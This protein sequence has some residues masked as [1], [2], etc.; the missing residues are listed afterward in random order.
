MNRY[1]QARLVDAVAGR[2]RNFA[3]LWAGEAVSDL[4]SAAALIAYPLLTLRLTGQADA[5]GLVMAVAMVSQLLAGLP[6]GLL[7][8]RLDRRGLMLTCDALRLAWQAGLVAGLATDHVGLFLVLAVCAADNAVTVVF[9]S[10]QVVAVRHLVATDQ[11]PVAIARVQARDAGAMLAGPPLGGLLFAIAP[12]LPFA[13]N[14]ASYLVSFGC[15][16]LIR[17]PMRPPPNPEASGAR[18]GRFGELSAGLRWLWHMPFLRVTLLL[19]AGT[20]V[21]SN[22]LI[23]I[24]IVAARQRG[25]SSAATGLLLT[26]ATTGS[27]I[28]ALLAPALV[29]RLAIRAILMINRLVWVTLIPLLLVSHSVYVAGGL[30]G[31]MFLLGPSGSTAVTTRRMAVTPDELQGR[32]SSATSF[33][34]GI[35]APL[36]TLA[37]AFTLGHLGLAP[38]VL[39]LTGW[40]ALLAT[41]TI[42]SRSLK[43]DC[44][45]RPSAHDE[46]GEPAHA[47]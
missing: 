45:L 6:G 42:A 15:I 39:A 35:A 11:L 32:A 12:W 26:M 14:S 18:H 17:A 9:G 3:L 31:L 23:L 22:A 21:A 24:A 41:V 27:L 37:I 19:I 46:P 8:D 33:C 30:I 43:A 2:G 16:A 13:F 5:V 34:A 10:A 1:L 25:D 47:N 7:V 40:M 29:K 36:G 44:R 20:N 4:G 38:A 28:G